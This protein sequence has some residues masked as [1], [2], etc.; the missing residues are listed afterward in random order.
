MFALCLAACT[1]V[2]PPPFSTGAT[3]AVASVSR[4]APIGTILDAS[5]EL[6]HGNTGADASAVRTSPSPDAAP[7]IDAGALPQTT[8]LPSADSPALRARAEALFNAIVTNDPEKALPFF[9]P[10]AAYEQVKDVG[11][12]KADWRI[13][14]VGAYRRDILALHDELPKNKTELAFK[15]LRVG[16]SPRWVKPGE[17]WNK[18]GYQRVYGSELVYSAGGKLRTL[19]LT[20]MIAW[21]GEWYVVHLR[22]IKG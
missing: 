4:A 11:N 18:I 8:D 9:F 15:E 13:R 7:T 14:L 20:S 6:V 1:Q 22:S 2:D 17:E 16:P 10:L 21:R 12:P 3:G 5:N 19:R